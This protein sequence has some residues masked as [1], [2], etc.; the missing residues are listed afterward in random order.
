[1]EPTAAVP[2]SRPAPRAS[3]WRSRAASRETLALLGATGAVGE[4]TKLAT[5]GTVSA[6]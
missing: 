6:R 4:V 5:L 2:C 1:M 3:P